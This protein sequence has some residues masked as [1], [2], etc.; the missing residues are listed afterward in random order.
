MHKK[1]LDI[2]RLTVVV[3]VVAHIKAAAMINTIMMP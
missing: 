3:M 1:Y 2:L